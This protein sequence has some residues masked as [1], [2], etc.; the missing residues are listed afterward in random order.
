MISKEDKE[1]QLSRVKESSQKTGK[2]FSV[3]T[4]ET[5]DKSPM[6]TPKLRKPMVTKSKPIGGKRG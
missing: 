6:E 2:H 3:F 1:K 4:S 5:I